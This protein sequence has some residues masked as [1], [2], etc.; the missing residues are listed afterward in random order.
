[1]KTWLK[2]IISAVV[3][4]L[5]A[6]AFFGDPSWPVT[7]LA[8]G[9]LVIQPS[10]SI[11]FLVVLA[12]TPL[13]GRFFCKC[14]CP[15]GIVQSIAARIARPRKAVRRVC[16]RLPQSK[17]QLAVRWSVFAAFAI[18]CAIGY[19][20]LAHMLTPYSIVGKALVLFIPGLVMF[21]LVVVSAFF[22]NG[23]LWCNWVCPVGS[24]F[25]VLSLKS[26]G[27]DKVCKGCENCRK[28]FPRE[29]GA[30]P[31]GGDSSG[32]I[33]RR[34]ALKGVAV[35]AA[36]Q[37]V[38]KTTDGGYAPVSLPGLPKRPANVLP[39][40]AVP[41]T[42]FNLKCVG[43]GL[44]VTRCPMNVLRQSTGLKTF[45]QPEMYF[46]NGYCRIACNYKCAAACPTGALKPRTEA[47]ANLH[48]GHAIWKKDLCI[49]NAKGEH[50]TACVRNC[51]VKAL[52]VVDGAI[53]I[54]KGA[55]IGCG[56]CEHVC[57]ARPAP[58]IF[59]KGF[60]RQREVLPMGD[61]DLVAEMMT[62]VKAGDSCVLAK[63]G[64]IFAR[65][66]G[67]GIKPILKLLD[68]GRLDGAIVADKIIG[69]A[70]A[71][72]CIAGGAR[73]VHALVMSEGAKAFLESRGVKCT[74]AELV[75]EIA[76]RDKTGVCPMESAVRDLD[77]PTRMIAALMAKVK[78]LE[79]K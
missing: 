1:M 35:L 69:R 55:C 46:Q 23:R 76:N 72:I 15:L 49:R 11:G 42:E 33:T 64:V 61:S 71:A 70:A 44:C 48:M 13:W 65:V 12:L 26:L 17:A 9:S 56:A 34:S 31:A 19:G 63:G 14:L 4:A 62:R 66:K 50:C 10:F 18:A 20:A 77:N 53:V 41:R 78:E 30:K 68:E 52:H 45:G 57:P 54:D 47:R 59:V 67:R 21:A 8:V 25:S 6:V 79:S 58:A 36:T 43:C 29:G 5:V 60:D 75:K 27:A 28:C 74:A 38:E 39:P 3:L 51:P 2:R 7:G 37:V 40:G 32:D 16:T 22:G 24:V 73:E